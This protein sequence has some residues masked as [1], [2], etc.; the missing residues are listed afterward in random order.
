MKKVTIVYF[1]V[2]R[3]QRGLS[4]EEL[5]T[6]AATFGDL[7]DELSTRFGLTLPRSLVRASANDAFCEMADPVEE[8]AVVVFI[9]PVAGG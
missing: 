9:P 2:L 5:H 3:E 6:D 8:G 1:A 7:Y 4:R